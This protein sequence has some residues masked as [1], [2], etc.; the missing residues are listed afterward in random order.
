MR[1]EALVK[2]RTQYGTVVLENLYQ[3]HNA[4]AVMRS[5]DCFGIQT[6]HIIENTNS[7]KSSPDV[8]RGSSKWL[9]LKHYNTGDSNTG[10]C[11]DTLEAEGYKLV[12]TT[13][14][15][16]VSIDEIPI[17]QPLA[18]IFGTEF[19]GVSDEVLS[20]AHYKAKVRMFGFTESFN[21]SVAAAIC[22]HSFRQRLENSTVNWRLSEAEQIETLIYWCSK[23]L[24]G[25]EKYY[26]TF[27][28]RKNG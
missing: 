12:A 21:I 1:F 18:F 15:T 16:D 20:R 9:N 4:S 2:K 28:E 7:W 10:I 14:H 13:P 23:T 19:K 11:L 6:V 27:E 25:Y 24:V 22:M 17:D 8:E 3:A 26:K 5:C